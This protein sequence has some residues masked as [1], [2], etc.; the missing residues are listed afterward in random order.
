[1]ISDESKSVLNRARQIYEQQLRASLE[2]TELGRYVTI[3][4]VSGEHFL[5]NTFDDAVNAALEKY[6]DRLSHT[7]RIG[8]AATLH[9]GVLAR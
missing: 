5:G 3:E 1:M 4:P 7:I 6:P 2:K 9:L 8:H